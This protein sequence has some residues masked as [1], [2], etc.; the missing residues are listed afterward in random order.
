VKIACVILL[1][2][3]FSVTERYFV[4]SIELLIDKNYKTSFL[5]KQESK[6]RF[7]FSREW[8]I[9]RQVTRTSKM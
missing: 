2:Y 7:P 4:E 1:V 8:Q 5:R 3:L 6:N 9:K